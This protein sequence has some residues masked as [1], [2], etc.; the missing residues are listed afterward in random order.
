MANC[1]VTGHKGYIGT[2][3]CAA[4]SAAGHNV[5]GIDLNDEVPHDI[6]SVLAE[7]HDRSFHPLYDTFQPEYV[8]HLACWPRIG[9]CLEQPVTTMKNNV[10]A[11]SVI[12]NFARKCKS[13]KRLI[14]SSSSSVEGN[15]AGPTNPYALHKL[16]T[17]KECGIYSEVYGLDTVSLR[18]FNVYSE[19]QRA[20]GPYATAVA[21]WRKTIMEKRI[22]F[23]TGT[24]EQRRD[25]VHVNDVVA[26]NLFAMGYE[27][28]FNG[29]HYDVG[30]GKNI[31]L[32]EMKALVQK[33]HDVEFEYVAP[34]PGEVM[35]TLANTSALKDLGWEASVS[36]KEGISNCFNF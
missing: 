17:E 36:I 15:G 22:P 9:F 34:R 10:L 12:L 18:Y 21:N 29:Q 28:N 26:A 5:L 23:I 32:N 14:Y 4:L 11:G 2:K 1:L 30:T 19:D 3:V 25:M 6:I 7:D 33:Y 24:G 27:G 13:V 35:E 20:N 16:I 31:S 8:F